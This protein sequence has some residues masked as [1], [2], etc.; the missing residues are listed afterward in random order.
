MARWKELPEGLDPRV[1]RLVVELRRLKDESDLSL[2]QFAGRTGYSA[3][4]WDRYLGG[5]ALPPRAALEALAVALGADEAQL[6]VLLDTADEAW[7]QRRQQEPVPARTEAATEAEADAVPP[8]PLPGG[9]TG[10]ALPSGADAPH[11][12]PKAP[13]RRQLLT[14]AVAALAGAAVMWAALQPAH[15]S[16]PCPPGH[17]AAA[18]PK[19]TL[20]TC[21]YVQKDGLWYAGN[22]TTRDRNLVVDMSG[23]DVAELQ[24]L[25][26][27]AGDTP[28]GI[29]GSFGPLT[30]AA[31]IKAQKA[32]H[33][34]VDGQVGPKTWAAL[35]G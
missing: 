33:L 18:V 6:L 22:S 3:S 5:R 12:S 19:R 21:D 7:R 10:A 28:G 31:V 29:D 27:R 34:D 32:F 8:E 25:L 30:E 26:Q 20:F 2:V 11:L 17:A 35:R 23:P 15:A 14:G 16:T 13:L 24:C 4:S 1:V 9:E